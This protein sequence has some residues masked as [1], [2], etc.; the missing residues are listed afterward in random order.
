[1]SSGCPAPCSS[2]L[3]RAR[4]VGPRPL[5]QRLSRTLYTSILIFTDTFATVADPSNPWLCFAPGPRAFSMSRNGRCRLLAEAAG[6]IV[7]T[8]DNMAKEPATWDFQTGSKSDYPLNQN[9]SITAGNNGQRF[10]NDKAQTPAYCWCS[11]QFCKGHYVSL[12]GYG[13]RLPRECE[14]FVFRR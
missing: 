1:M 10:A 4:Y 11:L 8:A 14:N 7:S 6:E 13:T 5:L 3:T 9:L 12:R 2:L